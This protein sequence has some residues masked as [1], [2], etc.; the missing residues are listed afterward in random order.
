MGEVAGYGRHLNSFTV[1]GKFE[2]QK[3]EK[4]KNKKLLKVAEKAGD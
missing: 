2:Q 1:K 4:K 3:T